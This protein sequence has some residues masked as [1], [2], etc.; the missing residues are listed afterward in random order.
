[1]STHLEN[2]YEAAQRM[3]GA[4]YQATLDVEDKDEALEY[5]HDVA[6]E[7]LDLDDESPQTV[8]DRLSA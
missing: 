7:I 1:M 6:G 2:K 3:A 5:I 8:A 4:I